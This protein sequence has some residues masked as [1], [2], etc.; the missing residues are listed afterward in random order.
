[1]GNV[2]MSSASHISIVNGQVISIVYVYHE[3]SWESF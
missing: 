2:L 1:M 3:V